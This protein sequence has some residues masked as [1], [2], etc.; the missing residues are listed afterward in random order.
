MKY[1][2]QQE[3]NEE[4]GEDRNTV[5]EVE[6][7]GRV[8]QAG[9]GHHHGGDEQDVDTARHHPPHHAVRLQFPDQCSTVS[10]IK[11]IWRHKYTLTGCFKITSSRNFYRDKIL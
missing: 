2:H 1:L 4:N 11:L 9:G 7:W 6:G 5:L 3:R 8:E 10:K